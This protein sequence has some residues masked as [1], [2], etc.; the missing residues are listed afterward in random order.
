MSFLA[1][2]SWRRYG[3]VAPMGSA[4]ELEQ[5]NL[6]ILHAQVASSR[7][8]NHQNACAVLGLVYRLRDILSK[9]PGLRT[10]TP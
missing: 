4:L 8:H 10:R 3:S 7:T 2:S 1:A 5:Y 9:E 6:L